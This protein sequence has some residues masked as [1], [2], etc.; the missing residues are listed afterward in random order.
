MILQGHTAKTIG[1]R[2]L[3][4]EN[5]VI[6]YRKRAYKKLNISRKSQLIELLQ[7]SGP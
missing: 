5:S 2:L 4:S 3:L 1:R 6:T 7:H